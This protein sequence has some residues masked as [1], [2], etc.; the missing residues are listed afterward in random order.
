LSIATADVTKC[1]GCKLCIGACPKDAIAL[2]GEV[3]KKGYEVI[4]VDENKCI[5]CG[6][7]YKMCPDY[8]FTVE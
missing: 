4:F 5:G 8:V 6:M 3:N 2:S 7:C 1:K